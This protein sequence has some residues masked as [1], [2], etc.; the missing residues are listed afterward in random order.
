MARR[1]K[2]LYTQLDAVARRVPVVIVD[3]QARRAASSVG[4]VGDR[5]LTDAG[6][7]GDGSGALESPV[8]QRVRAVLGEEECDRVRVDAAFECDKAGAAR[9]A[10]LVKQLDS[11]WALAPVGHS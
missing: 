5:S 10:S 7:S 2:R 4:D 6:G 8:V 1:R 9:R 11:A 3:M